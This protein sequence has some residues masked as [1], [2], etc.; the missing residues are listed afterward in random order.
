MNKQVCRVCPR[1]LPDRR[2]SNRRYCSDLCRVKAHLIRHEADATA[3]TLPRSLRELVAAMTG[4]T[5]AAVTLSIVE[6]ALEQEQ[7]QRQAGEREVERL[8]EKLARAQLA[9]KAAEQTAAALRRKVADM[10]PPIPEAERKVIEPAAGEPAPR[11]GK[12]V[13]VNLAAKPG[14]SMV[15]L[16]SAEYEEL[17]TGMRTLRAQVADFEYQ[18]A[19]GE[20]LQDESETQPQHEIALTQERAR[21]NRQITA[22]Q[23]ETD[24]EKNDKP[25]K[26][27]A[28]HQKAEKEQVPAI[29]NHRSR[30]ADPERA[31]EAGK[32]VAR[33]I[34]KGL[35]QKSVK[36]KPRLP[37]GSR[38][39]RSSPQP[40]GRLPGKSE[41]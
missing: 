35:R 40:R 33:G 25:K 9:Q 17:L 12:S 13:V 10:Q 26:K 1:K 7:R 18:L 32:E 28:R 38:S 36:A 20:A 5:V 21:P 2:R 14:E 24:G 15:A 6:Q 39:T 34:A 30:R 27:N 16:S 29:P 19:E 37:E 11:I 41:R 8:K 22:A 31:I 4:F 3:P 23:A